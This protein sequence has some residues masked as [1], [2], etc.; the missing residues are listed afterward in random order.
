[1]LPA[2]VNLWVATPWGRDQTTLPRGQKTQILTLQF[3]TVAKSLKHQ[4]QWFYSWGVHHNMRSCIK[5]SPLG[6]LRTT[7]LFP[8]RA[9]MFSLNQKRLFFQSTVMRTDI[10]LLSVSG[11]V[12]RLKQDRN[13]IS[14]KVQEHWEWG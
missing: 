8:Q 1:M 7:P 6:R 13:S 5:E 14:S 11:W 9:T 2:S 3:I 10:Q 12:F 4:Q